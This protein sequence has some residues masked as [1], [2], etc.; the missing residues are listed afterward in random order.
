MSFDKIISILLGIKMRVSKLCL[1]LFVF[2]CV[3]FLG[4]CQVLGSRRKLLKRRKVN[5]SNKQ[6]KSLIKLEIRKSIKDRALNHN[7]EIKLVIK[8]FSRAFLHRDT[9][10]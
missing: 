9:S 3:L 7:N 1:N 2:S 6:C 10:Y 5:N 4:N 8:E